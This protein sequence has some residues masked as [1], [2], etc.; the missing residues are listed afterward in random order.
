MRLL[1]LAIWI[2][3]FALPFLVDDYHLTILTYIGLSAIVALG[4]VMLTG[5]A[6]LSSFGQAAYVG[7][8]RPTSRPF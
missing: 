7:F 2:V 1:G 5:Q 4:L 3:I 6:G 8:W